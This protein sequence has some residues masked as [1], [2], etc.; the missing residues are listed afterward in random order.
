MENRIDLKLLTPP[1]LSPSPPPL[2]ALWACAWHIVLVRLNMDVFESLSAE[3]GFKRMCLN[4]FL[5]TFLKSSK[6]ENC[7]WNS[8][9]RFLQPCSGEYS[10]LHGFWKTGLIHIAAKVGPG[11]SVLG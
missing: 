10:F 4:T 2:N 1:F 8:N 5:S 9:H 7:L 11:A 3:E 6:A